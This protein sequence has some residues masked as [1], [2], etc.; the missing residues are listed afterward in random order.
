M[1]RIR[2]LLLWL[3][4]LVLPL[5]GLAATSMLFCGLDAHHDAGPP[6][7]VVLPV[8]ETL[9][10]DA[11]GHGVAAHQAHA[12]HE[13]HADADAGAGVTA[14]TSAGQLGEVA[15]QCNLCASCCFQLAIAGPS[16]LP[17]LAAAPQADL[18]EPLVL[19]RALP[20][21]LPEKPPRA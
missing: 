5:Q 14:D 9:R 3:V 4:V 13:A 12:D 16:L 20:A 8:H 10:H 15:H 17:L 6:A 19:I 21:R 2:S 1:S 7:A 11:T 18:A